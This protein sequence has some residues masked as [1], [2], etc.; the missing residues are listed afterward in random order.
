MNNILRTIL[1]IYRKLQYTVCDRYE[2]GVMNP[3]ERC[4]VL[5]QEDNESHGDIVHPCVRYIP[6][7]FRGHKWWMAYTPYYSSNSA[8]ENPHLCWGE[9]NG[10]NPPLKWHVEDI[11][12][13]KFGRG[14]NS[15]PNLF[16][17]DDKL[18]VYWR[19]ND[20]E[21]L[22]I[23][24]L[25][26]GTF[27]KIYTEYDKQDI[28]KPVLTEILEFEDRETCPTFIRVGNKY[29]AYAMHLVF[30]NKLIIKRSFLSKFVALTDLLGFYSQQKFKGIAL[31]ESTSAEGIYKYER[32]V[33]FLNCNCLYRPWHMDLF[34]Y[35][36][37]IY[38][39]V[40]TNQCNADICLA[41]SEDGI[42][43]RFFK[44]PLITNK[45]IKMLGLYK[46][47]ALVVDGMFYLYYTSQS[48]ENRKLNKLFVSSF[49]F[50]ELLKILN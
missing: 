24:G 25:H 14:Y 37:A 50:H 7:G 34:S 19:E 13:E 16:Y 2:F 8:I 15:D 23:S 17:E 20:T 22:L 35:E 36:G 44:K 5:G 31:W 9:E 42:N 48:P 4:K 26:R 30:K 49:K 41:K 40:Q 32:S 43:F 28:E 3:G 47:T 6:E 29:C 38:T 21:R 11:V 33:K 10:N 27:C 18:Y 45:N 39:I 1:S 12:M 46:P